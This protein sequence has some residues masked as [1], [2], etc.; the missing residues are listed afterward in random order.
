MLSELYATLKSGFVFVS[1][2]YLI[3]KP[4]LTPVLYQPRTVSVTF[5]PLKVTV[6]ELVFLA[7]FEASKVQDGMLDQVMV[8]LVQEEFALYNEK[9]PLVVVAEGKVNLKDAPVIVTGE[10]IVGSVATFQKAL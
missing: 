6:L 10:S 9:A 2:V 1:S 8:S 4:L 5:V 7:T 3:I